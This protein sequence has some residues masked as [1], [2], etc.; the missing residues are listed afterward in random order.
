MSPV[1]VYTMLL[2]SAST[3]LSGTWYDSAKTLPICIPKA[4]YNKWSELRR[5]MGTL[6]TLPIS[7]AKHNNENW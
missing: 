3:V 5:I 1:T 4:T 7:Q 6:I 2:K